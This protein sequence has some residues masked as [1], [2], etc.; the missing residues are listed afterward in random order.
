MHPMHSALAL[1]LLLSPTL[2]SPALCSP[3][4]HLPRPSL[5]LSLQGGGSA[6]PLDA[7]R[8][9][10]LSSAGVSSG[11]TLLSAGVEVSPP[12]EVS[13]PSSL[14]SLLGSLPSLS[15]L[16]ASGYVKLDKVASAASLSLRADA[17]LSAPHQPSLRALF[18]E[19]R[20][21]S[22]LSLTG[23]PTSL[24]TIS[25][26]FTSPFPFHP[27]AS[28][29]VKPRYVVATRTPSLSLRV[30][31]PSTSLICAAD[32][33]EQTLSLSQDLGPRTTIEPSYALRSREFELRV[34]RAVSPSSRVTASFQP[35]RQRAIV[36]W[37]DG[38]WVCDA[39]V[40]KGMERIQVSVRRAIDF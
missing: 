7:F 8:P 13:P 29:L 26:S 17:S 24:S 25:S 34:A 5:S 2:L 11:D 10:L 22:S 20:S 12:T 32:P 37:V 33:S 18:E 31:T 6:G 23:T 36:N 9:Q 40:P 15:S 3:T 27:A 16:P 1:L 21:G 30:G 14:S 38:A 19:R 35:A 4:L 39:V 28:L